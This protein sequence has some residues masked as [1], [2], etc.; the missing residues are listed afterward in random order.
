MPG[1]SKSRTRVVLAAAAKRVTQAAGLDI[2]RL[3]RRPM[4]TLL[5]IAGRDIR[6][7]FDVGANR[8]DFLRSAAA[9]FPEA[10]HRVRTSP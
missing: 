4:A 6:T 3:D 1:P 2:R 8:G 10:R 9:L 5:G 7:V